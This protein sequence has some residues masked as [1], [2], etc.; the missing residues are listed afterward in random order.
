MPVCWAHATPPKVTAPDGTSAPDRG[1]SI[2]DAIL[3]GPFS[4]QP[5]SV[6]YAEKSANFV[7]S[8]S[9]THLHAET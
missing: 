8:M 4:L 9:T 1:T 5:R 7:T 3:T 6:Q 2:R